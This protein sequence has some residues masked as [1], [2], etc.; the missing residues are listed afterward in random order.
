MG[1]VYLA[2]RADG[3]FEQRVGSD[4]MLPVLPRGIPAWFMCPQL[5]ATNIL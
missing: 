2:E 5:A 3:K 1:L 4:K